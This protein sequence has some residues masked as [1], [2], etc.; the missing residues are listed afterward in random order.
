MADLRETRRKLKIA[1][2]TMAAIDVVAVII[3]LSPLVGSGES[4]KQEMQQ[5]QS[6]LRQKTRQVEPLRGLDK[7][8]VLASQEIDTFYRERLPDRESTISEELGKLASQSGVKIGQAKYDTKE[9]E[10]VGLT[11][12][13][14]EATCQGDYLQLMRFINGLERDKT[15][16]IVNSV[17]LGDAQGGSVK[18]QLKLETYLRS[19]S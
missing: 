3:L 6:E 11:P 19:G 17:V 10:E 13:F 8:V 4:R 2:I 7:K 15:F 18:L 12:F 14:I 5:L 16:F 1:I 9:A